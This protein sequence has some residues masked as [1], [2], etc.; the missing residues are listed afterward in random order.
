MKKEKKGFTLIELLVVIAVIGILA[1]IVLI[2]LSDAQTRARDARITASLS[3]I[4]SIAE[5]EANPLGNYDGVC[6]GIE[7][8]AAYGDL[9]VMGGASASCVDDA[10]GWCVQVT[11]N[12]GDTMC[13]DQ[14][15]VIEGDCTGTTPPVCS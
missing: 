8:S 2:N 15:K 3:Q 12:A 9:T 4:R 14:E 11:N 5:F 1:T 10:D 6:D 13:A 7:I